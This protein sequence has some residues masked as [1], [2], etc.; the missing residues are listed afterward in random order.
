MY[1]NKISQYKIACLY[2][3]TRGAIQQIVEHKTYTWVI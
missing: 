1:K 2:N 3:V